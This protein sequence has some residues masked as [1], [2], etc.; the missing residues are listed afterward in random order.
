MIAVRLRTLARSVALVS[1]VGLVLAGQSAAR[2]VV[3][4]VQDTPLSNLAGVSCV[5]ARFCTAVSGGNQAMSWDGTRWRRQATPDPLR[6]GA[7]A[8]FLP[9]LEGVSCRSAKFCVAVGWYATAF[10]LS[11]GELGPQPLPIADRWNGVSWSL[12]P[13]PSWPTG[14]TWARM[15]G[16]S[17]TTGG[18]CMAVGASDA[19][20]PLSELWDGSSWSV[21][22]MP[23]APILTI[24]NALSCW[25][26]S[27]CIAVGD[28][29]YG[30][31]QSFAEIWNGSIWSLQQTA[32][33]AGA[34]G[35]D[36]SSVSCTSPSACIAVGASFDPALT[37][38]TP[39]IERWNGISWSVQTTPDPGAEPSELNGVSCTSSRAC[40]AVGGAGPYYQAQPLVER[41]DGASWSVE[42]VPSGHGAVPQAV[43]CASNVVCTVLG[44][45]PGELATLPGDVVAVQSVPAS[46]KLSG[47]PVRCASGP[48]TLHLTG[49][50]ISSVAWSLDGKRIP[51]RI[52]DSGRRYFASVRLSPGRHRLDVKVKFDPS[53]QAHALAFHRTARGCL[54]AH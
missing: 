42:R 27:F 19:A 10:V 5:S 40:T 53:S 1:A 15:S 32:Q 37:D 33:V 50:G 22:K 36:L 9:E 23:S 12:L 48:F 34:G 45:S 41:W 13:F 21:E 14:A 49:A 31:D 20:D 47:I 28:S 39:L 24:V 25:S 38:E 51:G 8:D 18:A 6:A 30:A 3:W 2:G 43:S 29:G 35:T 54:P 11:A 46:A 26:S 16:V 44:L 52:V 17:C 7:P 4:S